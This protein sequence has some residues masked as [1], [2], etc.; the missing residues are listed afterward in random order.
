M[1]I[2]YVKIFAVCVLAAALL[3]AGC[4]RPAQVKEEIPLVR[5]QTLQGGQE[6]AAALYAGEVRGRYE[7]QL[8]F[9]VGG[10]VLRRYVETGSAVQAGDVLLSIDARDI[11]QSV[12]ISS[13][14]VA[15]AASELKLAESNLER[16]RRLTAQGA[17]S[18]SQLDSYQKAYDVAAAAWQQAAAQNAQDQNQLG[19]SELIAGSRGVISQIAVEA[20]QVV[21]AG[22]IVATLIQDDELEVEINVPENRLDSLKPGGGLR[23]TFW[24]LPG[25]SASGVVREISPVADKVTRTYKVRVSMPSPPAGVKLGMTAQAALTGSAGQDKPYIPLSAVYQTGSSP[26]VWV[27]RDG[28]VQL[29]PIITG[30]FGPNSVE[31]LEGLQGGETIVTAGVQKLRDGQKVRHE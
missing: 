10:K 25:V 18:Q 13:A 19:Y 3:A 23:L 17:V 12:A 24:A 21:S 6:G 9:Q 26:G 22:Q 7:T 15:S 29:R 20:G 30:A 11:R 16:Y 31:V 1:R 27:I 28:A 2:P 8:A 5:V 4:A 14:R